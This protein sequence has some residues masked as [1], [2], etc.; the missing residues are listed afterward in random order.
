MR[1]PNVSRPHQRRWIQDAGIHAVHVHGL[2]AR[3][4]II[5]HPG[6]SDQRAAHGLCHSWR[7]RRSHAVHGSFTPSTIQH[8]CHRVEEQ[9][10]GY[11]RPI[12][13]ATCWVQTSGC[14]WT[15]SSTLM[16]PYFSSTV[17]SPSSRGC[18]PVPSRT[19]LTL[20]AVDA[21]GIAIEQQLFLILRHASQRTIDKLPG[22]G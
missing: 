8:S 12:A 6:T 5:G 2:Q 17:C 11:D 10:A 20:Q 19:F 9:Y 16:S 1:R 4:G 3:R 7:R 13:P 18:Q 21:H 14:S 22:S 15:W